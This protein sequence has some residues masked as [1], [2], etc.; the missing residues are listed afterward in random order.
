MTSHINTASLCGDTPVED[1]VDNSG[2]GLVV[3]GFVPH[4]G[5]FDIG[6][7]EVLEC[8]LRIQTTVYGCPDGSGIVVDGDQIECI[9]D[10]VVAAGGIVQ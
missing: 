1:A 5:R 6:V 10:I 7:P 4:F 2:L 9:G 3:F 8:S